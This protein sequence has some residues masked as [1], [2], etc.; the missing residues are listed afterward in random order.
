MANRTDNKLIN[1]YMMSQQNPSFN[2]NL[3]LK[4]S[5]EQFGDQMR[6][7][8]NT[9]NI[10]KIE[11]L[12]NLEQQYGVDRIRDAIIEPTKVVMTEL[13]KRK[14]HEITNQLSSEY[15]VKDKNHLTM[16][17][18]H[19]NMRTNDP[20][21]NIIKDDKYFSKFLKEN[22]VRGK[23][24]S[25]LDEKKMMG[26]LIVHRVTN[27]D[28]DGVKEKFDEFANGLEKHNNELKI[29]YSSTKEAEHA[30]KFAYNHKEKFRIKYN[31]SD[32]NELKS[33]KIVMYKKVQQELEQDKIKKDN[34]LEDLINNGTLVNQPNKQLIKQQTS[35]QPTN[36]QP[37]IRQPVKQPITNIKQPTIK[38]PIKQPINTT[39][40]TNQ[41]INTNVNTNIIQ[42]NAPIKIANN[43][44]INNNIPTN[45]IRYKIDG[46]SN[47]K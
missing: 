8:K 22:L 18:T 25:A 42:K 15:D 47:K 16:L 21:K 4:N 34:I 36:S 2:N 28:K 33:N 30:Q 10:N 27:A 5:Y 20:Y 19:W 38:Q 17:R 29:I 44:V 45:R 7:A 32:H 46:S 12:S 41:N 6:Q 43:T 39:I 13:E 23:R 3:L 37:I 24:V 11:F 35:L 31:P 1:N 40:N 9:H 26:E 14:Q